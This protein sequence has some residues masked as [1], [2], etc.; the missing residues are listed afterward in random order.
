MQ[1]EIYIYPDWKDCKFSSKE[2]QYVSVNLQIPHHQPQVVVMGW[3]VMSNL[4][5]FLKIFFC[6]EIYFAAF[7]G[8]RSMS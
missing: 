5:H 3:T 7:E 4:H 8:E 6:M 2:M 1:V